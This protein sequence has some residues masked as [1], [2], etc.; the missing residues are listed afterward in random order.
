MK[1]CPAHR[2][3]LPSL[4]NVK[5][6]RILEVHTNKVWVISC[7]YEASVQPDTQSHVFLPLPNRNDPDQVFSEPVL[8]QNCLEM[9]QSLKHWARVLPSSS[10]EKRAPNQKPPIPPPQPLFPPTTSVTLLSMVSETCTLLLTTHVL[11]I[12]G[13]IWPK[14]MAPE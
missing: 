5:F 9:D 14:F 11:D 12:Q 13:S 3:P 6:E 8:S 10:E 2:L 1:Q 4:H 7:H